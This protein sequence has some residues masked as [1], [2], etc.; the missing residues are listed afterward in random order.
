[1]VEEAAVLPAWV[2]ASV[3]LP[4]ERIADGYALGYCY[5]PGDAAA[6]VAV[7]PPVAS[8]V[9]GIPAAA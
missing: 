5:Y 8:F 9:S 4:E 2:E 6:A 1:M 3:V 7:Q